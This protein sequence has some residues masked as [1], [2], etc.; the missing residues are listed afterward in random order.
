ME[1][2]IEKYFII[3]IKK[4]LV[5]NKNNKEKVEINFNKLISKAK[6]D[7]KDRYKN[8]SKEEIENSINKVYKKLKKVEFSLEK[9]RHYHNLANK[10]YYRKKKEEQGEEVMTHKENAL[11]T[12]KKKREK[13]L[14][15]FNEA[16]AKVKEEGLKISS[17]NI[18]KIIERDFNDCLKLTSIKM[19]LK[20]I[21]TN[22]GE[23]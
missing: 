10:K 11:N 9:F 12:A 23:L 6:V 14:K 13:S 8:I 20:E 5:A 19:Y 21:K 18:H 15:V 16:L 17:G 3:A 7:F 22:Q 2:Q 1:Q 4:I